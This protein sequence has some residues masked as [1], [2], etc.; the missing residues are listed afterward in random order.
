MIKSDRGKKMG[1]IIIQTPVKES[2]QYEIESIGEF[3]EIKTFLDE[4]SVM[5]NPNVSD[6]DLYDMACVDKARENLR[7]NG[8]V[9]HSQVWD[10]VGV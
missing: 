5:E 9:S 7:K 1:Q 8:S 3:N 4:L 2:F 10:N 6:E